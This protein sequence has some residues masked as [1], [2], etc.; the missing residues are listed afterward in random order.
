MWWWP[1]DCVDAPAADAAD[2]AAAVNYLRVS[3]AAIHHD[4]DARVTCSRRPALKCCLPMPC[5][6]DVTRHRFFV[7]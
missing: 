2:A 6:C 3:L 4:A 5:Y 1:S 7:V